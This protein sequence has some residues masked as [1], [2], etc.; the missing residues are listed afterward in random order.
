MRVRPLFI[1]DPEQHKVRL[2][3]VI[4]DVGTVGD[5]RG[6]SRKMTF[7]LRRKLF[8][9]NTFA[10]EDWRIVILGFEVHSMTSWGGHYAY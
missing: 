8:A 9:W 3:R 7:A 5:G 1:H 6:Y 4:W 2:V 10:R